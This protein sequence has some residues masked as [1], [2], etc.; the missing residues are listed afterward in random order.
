MVF[1]V[2][3][4]EVV[5]ERARVCGEWC[6]LRFSVFRFPQGLQFFSRVVLL[7]GFWGWGFGGGV[8]AWSW[9]FRADG[10]GLGFRGQGLCNERFIS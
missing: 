3:C 5:R 8:G 2:S 1:R 4:I 7:S 10:Q 6:K 9:G